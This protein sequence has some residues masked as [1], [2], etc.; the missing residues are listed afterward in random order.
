MTRCR[1]DRFRRLNFADYGRESSRKADSVSA[2]VIVRGARFDAKNQRFLLPQVKSFR[3]RR[4]LHVSQHSYVGH[5]AQVR[6]SENVNGS[7]QIFVLDRY[8]EVSVIAREGIEM[9]G[10]ARI[11][12]VSRR[13]RAVDLVRAHR[14]RILNLARLRPC[15]TK[16][17][18]EREDDQAE[19]EELN[20]HLKKS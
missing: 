1:C 18:K 8:G 20:H 6:C 4:R 16:E 12:Y 2:L 5:S 13:N 10:Q 7:V 9:S 17:Q 3:S 19:F 15:A 11:A 14:R